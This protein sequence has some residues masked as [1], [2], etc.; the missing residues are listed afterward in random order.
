MISIRSAVVALALAGAFAAP[1]AAQQ[2][3]K[4]DIPGIRNF[5]RVD[6]TV[7]CGG[8]TSPLAFTALKKQGFV[9][10]VNLR[11]A[12]EAGADIATSRTS[13]QSVG[14]KYIH[15]PLDAESPSPAVVD[16]FIKVV[17][18]KANQPVYIH[19]GSA[20][21]V[22]AVWLAKRLVVDKWPTE[23]ATQEAEAIGLSSPALKQFALDYAARQK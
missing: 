3:Q 20:N 13:A 2:V 4:Q 6:A 19:C 21:R 17:T 9:S 8:A 7:G 16:E 15:L 1:G 5:S 11:L 14:L 10:I 18:D 22:G 12:S 23:K